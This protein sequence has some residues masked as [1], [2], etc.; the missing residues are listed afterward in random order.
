MS[1]S[2]VVLVTGAT[3]QQGGSVARRLLEGGFRVRGITRHPESDAAKELTAKGTQMVRAEL[4]D[5]DSLATALE[6][7]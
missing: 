4:T 2:K 5:A 6:Q 1:N 3:G 7:V